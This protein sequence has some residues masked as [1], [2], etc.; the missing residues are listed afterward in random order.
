MIF[1]DNINIKILY[2]DIAA[3]KEL[4]DKVA[5][6]LIKADEIWDEMHLSFANDC[7][8]KGKAGV[9]TQVK[10]LILI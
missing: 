5:E 9:L 6:N 10:T 3:G 8:I 1:P 2:R 4:P 7:L